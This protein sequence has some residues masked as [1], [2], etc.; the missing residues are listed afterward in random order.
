MKLSFNG[1]QGALEVLAFPLR[2]LA[3]IFVC[4][5]LPSG[6]FAQG[7]STVAALAQVASNQRAQLDGE[8]EILQQD[9]KNNHGRLVYS[10]KLSD[11]TRV[12]LKFVDEPP[13]RL[14][15]GDHVRATG[16]L[17]GGSLILYS[18]GTTTTT[19]TTTTSTSM[20]L[21]PNTFG[22]Q[23]TLVMLVN[24]Q[25]APTIQ[26]WTAAQI[27]S[28]VF[29]TTGMSGFLQEAS[30]GQT[31]LTGDVYGWYT[32][33]ATSSSCDTNQIATDA[34]NAAT[35]SGVNLAAYTRLVYVFPYNSVCSWAGAATI[36]GSPS[37]SWINGG[38]TTTNALDLGIFAHEIGHNLGL[39]HSHG[40][41]CG[42]AT[43]GGQCTVWEYFDSLDAMGSGQGHYN[44]FQKER[45]GW[46]NYGSSPTITTL[47]SPGTYAYDLSA[48]E[49]LAGSNAKAL[50]ILKFTNPIT[51][52]SYYYYVEFRQ[53]LGFDS[54]LS[55]MS[56]NI[57]NGVVIHLV[58]DGNANS[59]EL[60]DM[61]PDSSTYFDWNDVALVSGATYS[62][63][64][65]G[66]AITTQAVGSAVTVSVGISQP[67]CLRALPGI[68]ISP[69]QPTAVLAGATVVY[70]VTLTD[71]DS[72]SCSPATFSL[73]SAIPYG[74]AATLSDSQLTL[75]P[76]A[77][78]ST[79]FSV[80]SVS[81]STNG[82]STVGVAATSTA[83][84]VY[85]NTASATYS[86]GIPTM[87]TA[88]SLAVSVTVAG[89]SFMPPG[90]VPISALV[91]NGGSPASGVSVTF[92]LSTPAGST[93]KQTATT[94]SNGVVT[95]NYKLSGKSP[96][97]TY[98]VVGQA[99]T[100]SGSA[101]G[102]KTGNASAATASA[103]ASSNTAT[104]SVQ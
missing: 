79:T 69:S 23:P 51:G 12:P 25:D 97:G 52:A 49:E 40:L 93:T 15:T 43:F 74:W 102:K 46:L 65:A 17:S 94:G 73:Q 10:L 85:S 6:A 58:Q 64:D 34:N 77:G 28:E 21:L 91:T 5:S 33:A 24:F 56:Q 9:F 3:A 67:S 39:Y 89:S 47:T 95:W 72:S 32:I 103:S 98:S 92:M 63:P 31:W 55:S 18:D 50:K 41:D 1:A 57:S 80:T 86:I 88:P 38:G 35:A 100:G 16:Q 59:S 44:S 71:N 90:A 42:A 54:F 37:Q 82:T 87:P 53:P 48:Y 29:A 81:N 101:G 26:P 36:G 11:G 61:T 96:A 99:S 45:L 76:G 22:A 7:N 20:S 19:T 2:L 66:L 62:D 13:T 30:Y 14:R 75:S 27:Q 68:S 60:L 84:F 104:F 78:G 70:T 4:T 83:D 8:L